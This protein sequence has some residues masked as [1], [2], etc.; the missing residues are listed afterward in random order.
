M[1]KLLPPYYY[2]VTLYERFTVLEIQHTDL[3]IELRSVKYKALEKI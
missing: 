1:L 2:R 3:E